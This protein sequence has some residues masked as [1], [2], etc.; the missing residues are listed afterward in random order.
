MDGQGPQ[1]DDATRRGETFDR[2][3]RLREFGDTRLGEP[4]E[5]MRV[6]QDPQRTVFS[7][8]VVEVNAQCN[9]AR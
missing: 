7:G 9:N 4:A 8:A 5:A 3:R 6:W 1:G 2:C